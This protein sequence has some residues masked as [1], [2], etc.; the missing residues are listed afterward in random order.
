M[1]S[2]R[3][4]VKHITSWFSSF[5]WWVGGTL[6]C[7][8]LTDLFMEYVATVETR[9]AHNWPGGQ[10]HTSVTSSFLKLSICALHASPLLPLF[11]PTKPKVGLVTAWPQTRP[12]VH[13]E[14]L[15]IRRFARWLHSTPWSNYHKCYLG[16]PGSQSWHWDHLLKSSSLQGSSAYGDHHV[17]F[18]DERDFVVASILILFAWIHRSPPAF[19]FARCCVIARSCSSICKNLVMM[20][21]MYQCKSSC[22]TTVVAA[23]PLPLHRWFITWA[24]IFN[25]C[26]RCW[27]RWLAEV[28]SLIAPDSVT[29]TTI[30]L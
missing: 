9:T 12:C 7:A 26:G 14:S 19:R 17:G 30:S 11:V 2:L 29:H 16:A 6:L 10:L 23:L 18:A 28:V 8:L 21:S 4:S 27:H 15:G 1:A 22:Q 13:W 24:W 20:T 5:A 3:P 25:I